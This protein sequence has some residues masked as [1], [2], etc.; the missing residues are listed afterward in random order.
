MF[1]GSLRNRGEPLCSS[2]NPDEHKG[3]MLLSSPRN[4]SL[5]I[6]L[7]FPKNISSYVSQLMF[8]AAT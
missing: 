4:V 3:H 7:D 5:I 1:L 6:F 2:G 8:L